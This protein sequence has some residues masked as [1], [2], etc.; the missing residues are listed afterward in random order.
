MM[1]G[2]DG[3]HA[4]ARALYESLGWLRSRSTGPAGAAAAFVVN[5]CQDILAVN[6]LGRAARCG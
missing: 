6:H 5:G 3:F 4:P 1:S 2:G